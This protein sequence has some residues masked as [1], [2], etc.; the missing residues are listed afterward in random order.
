MAG[1]RFGP[2]SATHVLVP[3]VWLNP[4]IDVHVHS[5]NGL[6]SVERPWWPWYSANDQFICQV[7]NAQY[8]LF[9]VDQSANLLKT[10]ER[11]N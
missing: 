5:R 7:I 8:G 11:K 6:G 9:L 10:R 2:N 4:I 1:V 3:F